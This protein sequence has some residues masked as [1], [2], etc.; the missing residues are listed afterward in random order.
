MLTRQ[1]INKMQ[2]TPEDL[3][4]N[5]EFI[6]QANDYVEVRGRTPRPRGLSCTAARGSTGYAVSSR[7]TQCC[8]RRRKLLTEEPGMYRLC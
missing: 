3:N 8:P 6:R 5:A 2:A 1:Y 7:P 4:A